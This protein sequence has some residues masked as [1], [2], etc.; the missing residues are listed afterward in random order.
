[1]SFLMPPKSINAMDMQSSTAKSGNFDGDYKAPHPALI[2]LR[3]A[4]PVRRNQ[5]EGNGM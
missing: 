2:H 5:T 3:G 1:M 4:Y